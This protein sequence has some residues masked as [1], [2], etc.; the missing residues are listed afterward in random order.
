MP[1]AGAR[2]RLW[3]AAVSRFTSIIH[4]RILLELALNERRGDVCKALGLSHAAVVVLGKLAG[5]QPRWATASF[6]RG[7][8]RALDGLASEAGVKTA[9]R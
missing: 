7:A 6:R 4:G 8:A 3:L 9:T 2:L 5:P 1:S